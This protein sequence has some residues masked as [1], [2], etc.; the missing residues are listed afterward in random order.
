[1]TSG[2][3]PAPH[4]TLLEE[5]ARGIR[6]LSRSGAATRCSVATT[7]RRFGYARRATR[8]E[9]P[10][11]FIW[12]LG[13]IPNL[14]LAPCCSRARSQFRR[15]RDGGLWSSSGRT[16]WI[17]VFPI[18]ELAWISHMAEEAETADGRVWKCSEHAAADRGSPDAADDSCAPRAE[19]AV[20]G[21]SL[22]YPG[23]EKKTV[24][25][26][27]DLAIHPGETLAPRRA[28][29]G[30]GEDDGRDAAVRDSTGA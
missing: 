3:N 24:L 6:V 19:V 17:L 5:A 11:Q 23:S 27:L 13:L 28:A 20:D 21:R 10:P 7:L 30:S 22:S 1:V 8:G 18:E 4:E 15:A 9:D 12:V 14:T 16:C 2:P 29:T 26:G 25:S